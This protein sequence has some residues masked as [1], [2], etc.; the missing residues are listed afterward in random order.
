[1]EGY[2]TFVMDAVGA[3]LL[4]DHARLKEMMERRKRSRAAGD[5]LFERLLGLELK[6]R[7]YEDGVKFCRYVAGVHDVA[8]L[9][10]AWDNP[11]SLPTQEEIA[12][13]DAWI[14]R[15]LEAG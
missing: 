1:V 7:Q 9:N 5:V 6:R 12:D 15:V 13:P 10:R 8:A 2:A 11:D 4:A 3:K 14:A